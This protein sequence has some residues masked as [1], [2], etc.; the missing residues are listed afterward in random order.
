MEYS[1]RNELTYNGL[2]AKLVNRY[3]MWGVL[4]IY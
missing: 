1:V 2:Q 4:V 3:F